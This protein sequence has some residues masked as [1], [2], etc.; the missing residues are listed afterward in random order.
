[1]VTLRL[2]AIAALALASA[3]SAA[4][5]RGAEICPELPVDSGFVWDHRPGPDFD[6][7]YAKPVDGGKRLFGIYLGLHPSFTPRA[8]KQLAP[9]IVD[10]RSVM[11]YA[12]DNETTDYA[13]AIETL[14]DLPT[15]ADGFHPVAHIWVYTST[16]EEQ[17][18]ILRLLSQVRFKSSF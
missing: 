2:A 15:T 8:E 12:A 4:Q 13:Y 11:W 3:A 6:L 1:M 14:L 9:S 5:E 18:Q 10:D 7:C 16:P 17:A